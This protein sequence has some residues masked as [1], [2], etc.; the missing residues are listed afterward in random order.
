MQAFASLLFAAAL[1]LSRIGPASSDTQSDLDD[2]TIIEK[3]AKLA[4]ER[5]ERFGRPGTLQYELATIK[6]S[7]CILDVTVLRVEETPRAYDNPITD[8]RLS[9]MLNT[10]LRWLFRRCKPGTEPAPGDTLHF[11]SSSF[12]LEKI[13]AFPGG[14]E[15]FQVGGQYLLLESDYTGPD[16]IDCLQFAYSPRR[17]YPVDE[18]G[19]V[20]SHREEEGGESMTTVISLE[21]MARLLAEYKMGE[22]D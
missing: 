15:Q 4:A 16:A 13:L 8:I 12:A 19:I 1:L 3:T 2:D 14:M 22:S 10:R 17:I 18:D 6:S 20:I 11:K 5:Q 21:E 9:T 7:M